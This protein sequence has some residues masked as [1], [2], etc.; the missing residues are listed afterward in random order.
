MNFPGNGLSGYTLKDANGTAVNLTATPV[1]TKPTCTYA[2][3][4]QLAAFANSIQD[5]AKRI[6]STDQLGSLKTLVGTIKL[7]EAFQGCQTFMNVRTDAS[8]IL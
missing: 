2:G 4:T 1:F 7:K 8:L 6:N 3:A 5:I